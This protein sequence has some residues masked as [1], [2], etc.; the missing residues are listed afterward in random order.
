MIKD[1]TLSF[2]SIKYIEGAEQALIPLLIANILLQNKKLFF[3]AKDDTQMAEI[4]NIVS[5]A[6]PNAEIISILHGI[7]PH[8]IFHPQI[9][10]Y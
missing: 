10:K 4:E 1:K 9:K 8:M 5:L 2:K 3:I 6:Q 7:P